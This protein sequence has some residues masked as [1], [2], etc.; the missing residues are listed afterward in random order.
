[1][2]ALLFVAITAAAYVPFASTAF[3]QAGSTGGTL[4]NTDKAISGDRREEPSSRQEPRSPHSTPRASQNAGCQRIVGAWAWHYTLG[5]T[6]TVFRSDGTGTSSTGLTSS[7]TCN[8]NVVTV[9]WS[10]G[11][12]D[13]AQISP[14]GRSLSITNNVGD[15]FSATRK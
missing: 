14:D 10:H 8:S 1:M 15:S 5:T 7:W 4:G 3:S 6:E 13:R 12:T 9:K 2:R 11:Y